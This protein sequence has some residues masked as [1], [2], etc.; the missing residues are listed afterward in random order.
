MRKTL[1]IALVALAAAFG[2]GIAA[3]A[4]D[5]PVDAS[6]D[7]VLAKGKL[8]VT[9]ID[10]FPPFGS[11]DEKGEL[12]GYEVD[13]ARLAAKHLGVEVELVPAVFANAIPYLLS[14]KVDALF[15]VVGIRPDRAKQ[16]AY[17]QPYSGT[18]LS[19]I[20]A[21]ATK[22]E[23]VADLKNLRV[24]V[25]RGTTNEQITVEN[26]PEGTDIR[27]FESDADMIQALLSGQVDTITNSAST[28]V[29]IINKANPSLEAESKILFRQQFN[30]IAVRR[31][32][33][34]LRRW[35]D[36]FLYFVKVNGELDAIHAKWF[37]AP[38]PKFPVL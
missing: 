1:A 27:R 19:I 5:N 36:T 14:G 23:T 21:K 24:G 30:G 25:S 8:V 38:L 7:R 35:F 15:N 28:V 20:A 17:S 29:G 34:D 31:E 9:V 11:V 12:V 33:N 13:V 22:V 16:I 26:A 3:R 37:N 4:Q 18:D 6:L 2:P 32:D 10:Q